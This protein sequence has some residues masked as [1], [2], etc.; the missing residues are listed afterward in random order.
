MEENPITSAHTA[1][2]SGKRQE[3]GLP[4]WASAVLLS[5]MRE[6]IIEH[7]GVEYHL[8]LTSQGKLILTK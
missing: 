2:S 6:V 5:G 1:S 3:E 7:S 4:R 8:R